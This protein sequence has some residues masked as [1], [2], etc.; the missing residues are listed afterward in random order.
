MHVSLD[1]LM[2][3]V[4]QCRKKI[5]TLKLQLEG[6]AEDV[7]R[8]MSSNN[9]VAN[10]EKTTMMIIRPK[11][12][13]LES[14]IKINVEQS[15]ILESNCEKFLGATITNDLMWNRH[16][17]E[18]LGQLNKRSEMISRI[19]SKISGVCLLP[20]VHGLCISKIRY[21]LPVYGSVRITEKEPKCGA[22]QNAQISLNKI[23]RKIGKFKQQEFH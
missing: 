8:F 5:D 4:Y 6:A 16:I 11:K 7:L 21:A 14:A 22:I 12:T 20:V 9:L 15:E 3:L 1:M 10:A 13:A 2:T 19:Q 18:L 23:L 17:K